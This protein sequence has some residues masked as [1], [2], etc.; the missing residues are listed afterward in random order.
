VLA[1]Y[2]DAWKR[3]DVHAL[4]ALLK[5][6]AHLTMPPSPAWVFGRDAI[7][8]FFARY[9]FGPTARPHLHV[10]TRA[11]RQPAYAVFLQAAEPGAPPDPFAVEVLRIQDG[12]IAEIHYFLQ[13][14]L[15]GRFAVAPPA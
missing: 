9:P 12:L 4:A 2:L 10:P 1:R 13:P 6:D 8:R 7:A 14:E 3:T 11:N 15:L 5:E